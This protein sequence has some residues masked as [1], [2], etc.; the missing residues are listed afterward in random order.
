MD[1]IFGLLGWA[2]IIFAAIFIPHAIKKSRNAAKENGHETIA[3]VSLLYIGFRAD[4]HD[5]NNVRYTDENGI[6]HEALLHAARLFDE[7]TSSETIELSC[8]VFSESSVT[9]IFRLAS[10]TS[11]FVTIKLPTP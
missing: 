11:K 10:M 7:G 9:L 2:I 6:E 1:M 8:A 4:D 5:Y 3:V